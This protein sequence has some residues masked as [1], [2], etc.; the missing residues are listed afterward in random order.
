MFPV[1]NPTPSPPKNPNN[2]MPTKTTH[3]T[4]KNNSKFRSFNSLKSKNGPKLR[5][6]ELNANMGA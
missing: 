3:Y 4:C 2:E 1:N 5:K 6:M